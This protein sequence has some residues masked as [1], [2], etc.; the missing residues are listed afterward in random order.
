MSGFTAGVVGVAAEAA[1]CGDNEETSG[2]VT[3]CGA[4]GAD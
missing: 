4:A 3:G 1:G 2:L